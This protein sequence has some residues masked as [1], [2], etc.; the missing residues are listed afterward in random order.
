[1]LSL[2]PATAKAS[3]YGYI[4]LFAYLALFVALLFLANGGWR[5]Y[6]QYVET[7]KWPAT[8]AQVI[9]CLVDFTYGYDGK[10]YG[11][12]YRTRCLLHYEVNGIPY[13][14][15]KIA[16]STVFVSDKQIN[17]TKP[18]VTVAMQ[19]E[20]IRSHSRGSSLTIHYDPSDPH[21]ISLIG[22]DAALQKNTPAEQ[23][24]I[25]QGLFLF[26]MVVLLA[27]F[28]VRKRAETS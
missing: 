26:G 15:K 2:R 13:D 28:F 5:S 18:K 12:K 4:F 16:G 19:R 17:L 14:A 7:T 1:M 11:K 21:Q 6:E 3:S 22:A 25:G 27:G 9:D 20:W 10:I 8:E 23:L 24:S